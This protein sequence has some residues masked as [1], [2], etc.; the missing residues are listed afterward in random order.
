MGRTA[1]WSDS[2]QANP[3]PYVYTFPYVAVRPDL[4][5]FYRLLY[6]FSCT[7]PTLPFSN[8]VLRCLRCADRTTCVDRNFQQPLHYLLLSGVCAG[9]SRCV[10]QNV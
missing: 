2:A 5:S 1:R 10:C 3:S 9:V 8:I 4:F 7:N 6:F